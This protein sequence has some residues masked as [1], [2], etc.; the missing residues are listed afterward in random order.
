MFFRCKSIIID[1]NCFTNCN[2]IETFQITGLESNETVETINLM[3]ECFVNS[4]YIKE[5]EL[6]ANK[7]HVD[8]NCFK[9]ATKLQ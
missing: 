7:I 6:K 2:K 9:G 1:K 5:I 8:D 3:S 4:N